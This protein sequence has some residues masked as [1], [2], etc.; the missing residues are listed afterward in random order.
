MTPQAS[1]TLP[2]YFLKIEGIEGESDDSKHKGELQLFDFSLAVSNRGRSADYGGGSKAVFQD[3]RF[4]A[5]ADI[6]FPKLE[7]ACATGEHIPKAVLTCRKAGKNQLDFFRVT[8]TDVLVTR[9]EIIAGNPAQYGGIPVVEFTLS[10]AKEQTE[11]R[12]QRQ[13]GTL[14]GAI[15]A[16]CDVKTQR[17]SGTAA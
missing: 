1:P 11:Y 15:T 8:F 17:S 7:L 5:P 6:A 4:I 14:G 12:E 13:D 2:D 10:Y 16:V 9:C 3:A